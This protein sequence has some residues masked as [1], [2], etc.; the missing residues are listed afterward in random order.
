MSTNAR[1]RELAQRGEDRAAQHVEELGW[2]VVERNWR[3]RA[4]ELD[5]VAHDPETDTLVF[6]EVKTRSGL[7]YGHPLEAITYAKAARLRGLAM[8]WLRERGARARL[9]RVDAI[10]I[11]LPRQGPENLTHLRGIGDR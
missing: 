10:G 7:G 3:C 4:G 2:R 6:I 8:A 11:V 5:L 9:L 1:A